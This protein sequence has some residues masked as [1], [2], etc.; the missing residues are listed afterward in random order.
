MSPGYSSQLHLT[1]SAGDAV[2]LISS[3]LASALPTATAVAASPAH[4]MAAVPASTVPAT[5]A[6]PAT[7]ERRLKVDSD[8]CTP[9]DKRCLPI[10]GFPAGDW[11][12]F[13]DETMRRRKGL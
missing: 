2:A 11:K 9:F 10:V 6:E 5:A 13:N 7:N 4:A 8:M 1:E 12:G 3:E